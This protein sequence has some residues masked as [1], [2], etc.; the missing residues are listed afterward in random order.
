MPLSVPLAQV[1]GLL[2]LK[3]QVHTCLHISSQHLP[4]H[5]P[6]PGAVFM[7]E[8][9]WGK[10]H[11]WVP[12]GWRTESFPVDWQIPSTWEISGAGK[13]WERESKGVCVYLFVYVSIFRSFDS[14]V[15][16][17]RLFDIAANF[18]ASRMW[19]RGRF[20]ANSVQMFG[21]NGGICSPLQRIFP[22]ES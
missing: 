1:G 12:P 10:L 6:W 5:T 18:S 22:C 4:A 11:V 14:N 19:Q 3:F 9:Q 13:I 2:M 20:L 16:M 8:S 17:P 21:V 15:H 7:P